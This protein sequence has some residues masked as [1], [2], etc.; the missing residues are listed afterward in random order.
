MPTALILTACGGDDETPD[1]TAAED[2]AV[3]VDSDE[4]TGSATLLDAMT[5]EDTAAISFTPPIP[6]DELDCR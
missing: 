1:P 6:P 3:T 2:G 5:Q 4:V